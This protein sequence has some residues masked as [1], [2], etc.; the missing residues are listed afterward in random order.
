M[1]AVGW[2]SQEARTRDGTLSVTRPAAPEHW[3]ARQAPRVVHRST[4]HDTPPHPTPRQSSPVPA[5]VRPRE[6][7]GFLWRPV[8][9]Q[10]GRVAPCDLWS[11]LPDPADSCPS[12][13]CS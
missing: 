11:R 6:R 5:H 12:P 3:Q 9:H 13:Q 1:T 4:P 8:T 10:E 2:L 7:R